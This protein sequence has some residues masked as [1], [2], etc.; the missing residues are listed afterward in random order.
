MWIF[1]FSP[2]FFFSICDFVFRCDKWESFGFMLQGNVRL[3]FTIET[4]P[5]C[6]RN[7]SC[8]CQNTCKNQA[9]FM[10]P[11]SCLA[12]MSPLKWVAL[13]HANVTNWTL[14]PGLLGQII[15]LHSFISFIETKCSS[16]SYMILFNFNDHDDYSTG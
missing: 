7:M 4:I 5:W 10:L 14:G 16:H 12:E 6:L 2:F 13:S 15:S 3:F 8:F 9:H 1:F 11:S